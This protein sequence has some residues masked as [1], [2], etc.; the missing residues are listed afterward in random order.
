MKKLFKGFI[1]SAILLSIVGLTG[2]PGTV[3]PGPNPNPQNN[4]VDPDNELPLLPPGHISGGTSSA[5]LYVSTYIKLNEYCAGAPVSFRNNVGYV[6]DYN[7]ETGELSSSSM[8]ESYFTS[9]EWKKW[10]KQTESWD[11]IDHVAGQADY[12]ITIY[13]EKGVNYYC[14]IYTHDSKNYVSPVITIE[15]GTN[16]TKTIGNFVYRDGSYSAEY[17]SEKEFVGFVADVND[18]GYPTLILY[19]D[20]NNDSANNNSKS[21]VQNAGSTLSAQFTNTK[22]FYWSLPSLPEFQQVFANST[23]INKKIADNNL[24]L[25]QLIR[26]GDN[27]KYFLGDDYRNGTYKFISKT[28][29][30][31]DKNFNYFFVSNFNIGKEVN[32][33][34]LQGKWYTK[35][36]TANQWES[37]NIFD[38]NIGTTV[39]FSPT[40]NKFNETT[41]SYPV[42]LS[43]KDCTHCD[44]TVTFPTSFTIDSWTNYKIENGTLEWADKTYYRS[45]GKA[46]TKYAGTWDNVDTQYPATK[47][48]KIDSTGQFADE[49]KS[50]NSIKHCV[51]FVTENRLKFSDGQVY[52]IS[53]TEDSNFYYMNFYLINSGNEEM[54]YLEYPNFQ[55][56]KAK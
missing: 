43:I 19:K 36:S 50:D 42:T 11:T 32:D 44:Y 52:C 12:R 39:E 40:E 4:T 35:K 23:L 33:K 16:K 22:D 28:N 3:T 17:N 29:S 21:S 34:A 38:G 24:E 9:G 1:A 51:F 53:F 30:S 26:D 13:A 47:Q 8:S 5:G 56:K 18:W 7:Y 6:Y 31:T 46:P 37:F 15:C 48:I 14:Y 55:F 54:A 20:I 49:I 2:C 45:I 27:N 10:N 25:N 41:G